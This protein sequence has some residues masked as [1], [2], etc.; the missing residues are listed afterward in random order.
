MVDEFSELTYPY[1]QH[2]S[3]NRTIPD[4]KAPFKQSTP[5]GNILCVF[6]QKGSNFSTYLTTLFSAFFIV[7][8]LMAVKWCHCEFN[9]LISSD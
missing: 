4:P 7:A 3:R 9:S 1:N 6:M 8:I 5:K 2:P